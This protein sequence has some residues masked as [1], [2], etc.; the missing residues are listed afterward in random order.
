VYLISRLPSNYFRGILISQFFER[1]IFMHK[2]FIK[3]ENFVFN[4]MFCKFYEVDRSK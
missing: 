1:E 3:D 4:I 2:S